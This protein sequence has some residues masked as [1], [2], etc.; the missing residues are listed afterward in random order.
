MNWRSDIVIVC[1]SVIHNSMMKLGYVTYGMAV[2]LEVDKSIHPSF[3][4]LSFITS[5]VPKIRQ[6][7]CC[8]LL[9]YIV[10]PPIGRYFTLS[11]PSILYSVA[12]VIDIQF[13]VYV[14]ALEYRLT[15][16]K[17]KLDKTLSSCRNVGG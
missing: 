10:V 6:Q 9:K 1:I 7:A 14:G 5:V 11:Y 2:E 8:L 4:S 16:P 17:N 15:F 13:A 12:S 3:W